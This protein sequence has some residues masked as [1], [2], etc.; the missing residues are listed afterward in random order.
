ME[1]VPHDAQPRSMVEMTR[2]IVRA[3]HTPVTVK[4]ASDG[5]TTEKHEIALPPPGRRDRSTHHSR[6]NL[7][8]DVPRRGRLTLIGAVKNNPAIRIPIIGN[9]D[10]DSGPKARGMSTD[11]ASTV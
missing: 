4:P 8:P 5:T 3:V 2:Q 6:A 1:P 11:T 9:G 10:V 7:R